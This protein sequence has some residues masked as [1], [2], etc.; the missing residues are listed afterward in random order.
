AR[1]LLRALRRKSSTEIATEVLAAAERSGYVEDVP[2]DV[3]EQE[4]T[5]QQDLARLVR[6]AEQFDDG[7]RTI[8]DFVADLQAR[9]GN[10]GEG[11]GVQLLT[12]HRA[13]GLEF[14][15][16]LLPRLQEGELP[17]K[18]STTTEAIAEERRLLYVGMTRART[19]LG[20]SWVNGTRFKPSR[21]LAELGLA[22]PVA[23]GRKE[24]SDVARS[25]QPGSWGE[26]AFKALKEWRAKRADADSVPAF[27]VFHDKTLFDIVGR[28]PASMREL[29]L[30]PGIGSTKL[31]R[32]GKD[33]LAVLEAAGKAPTGG[34]A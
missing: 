1:Q 23:T 9:F 22:T 24:P 34:G 32:Y 16:V 5:R 10:E 12:L 21:F 6:L 4:L 15:A 11:R 33:L 27:V 30:V 7:E 26:A 2:E 18:R 13:K 3:G 29:A 20:L 19:Y 25:F 17:F 31:E 14:D 8:A 28:R